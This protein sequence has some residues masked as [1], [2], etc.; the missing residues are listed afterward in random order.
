MM[1]VMAMMAMLV[2]MPMDADIGQYS[3]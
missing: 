3:R 2:M 1:P